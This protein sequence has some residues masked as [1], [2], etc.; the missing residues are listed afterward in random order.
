MPVRV[1]TTPLLL[2]MGPAIL[3]LGA[4]FL[5][6]FG[7]CSGGKRRNSN[8]GTG[9]RVLRRHHQPGRHRRRE[10]ERPGLR[11]PT[12]LPDPGRTG[13][14]I[15]LYW[16]PDD[17]LPQSPTTISLTASPDPESSFVTWG[18]ACA[19]SGSGTTCQ[20]TITAS[21]KSQ[22]HNLS[23]QFDLRPGAIQVTTETTGSDLDPDGYTV[24]HRPGQLRAPLGS[25][26]RRP[27]PTWWPG[28]MRSHW[29]GSPTTAP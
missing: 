25:M 4:L 19:S 8:N 15:R 3:A 10:R 23:A 17:Q 9:T 26:R 12:L 20:L 11:F 13:V 1:Q 14:R 18:G 24:T 27:S 6:V 5:W 29:K 28:P 2:R 16:N 22:T 21:P 7:G